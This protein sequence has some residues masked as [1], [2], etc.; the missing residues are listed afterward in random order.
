LIQAVRGALNLNE[1][2]LPFNIIAI[3]VRGESPAP[4]GAYDEAK[5]TW[6]E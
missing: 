2:D 6:I 1:N 5:V 3:G 4:R